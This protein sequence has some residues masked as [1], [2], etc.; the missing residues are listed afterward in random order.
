MPAEDRSLIQDRLDRSLD[1]VDQLLAR[2]MAD[3]DA[4]REETAA[5]HQKMTKAAA[6]LE[7]QAE[8]LRNRLQPVMDGEK[9]ATQS[10][11]RD[12]ERYLEAVGRLQQARL[13][14]RMTYGAVAPPGEAPL[15]LPLGS[16][17]SNP[18]FRSTGS[19]SDMGTDDAARSGSSPTSNLATV[20]PPNPPEDYRGTSQVDDGPDQGA[21]LERPDDGHGRP[22]R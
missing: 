1:R 4:A 22:V 2:T 6:A 3:Y 9:P 17:A 16:P 19:P 21:E 13:A 12:A 7:K 8:T 5:H 18:D 10:F 20:R 11:A 14:R 15:G